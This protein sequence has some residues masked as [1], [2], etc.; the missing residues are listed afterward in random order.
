MVNTTEQLDTSSAT[1]NGLDRFTSV[2]ALLF[3][4]GF[5]SLVLRAFLECCPPI[6]AS[7]STLIDLQGMR[8]TGTI[9]DGMTEEYRDGMKKW[10]TKVGTEVDGLLID[11]TGFRGRRDYVLEILEHHYVN[12]PGFKDKID[13]IGKSNLVVAPFSL[14]S[15]VGD[16]TA[17]FLTDHGIG[18]T[19]A[20]VAIPPKSVIT[21]IPSR[22]PDVPLRNRE[23]VD[24][25]SNGKI[26]LWYVDAARAAGKDPKDN[27]LA[28][29]PGLTAAPVAEVIMYA[30]MDP[31]V[32]GSNPDVARSWDISQI[33]GT[34]LA[35]HPCVPSLASS[36]ASPKAALEELF[37]SSLASLDAPVGLAIFGP[38]QSKEWIRGMEQEM[39]Q[40]NI[41]LSNYYAIKSPRDKIL[42]L[43]LITP[44]E[45][46]KLTSHLQ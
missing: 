15:S 10:D 41:T 17:H 27:Y 29:A 14:A 38:I 43:F 7:G 42:G 24:R 12:T 26:G 46:L 45:A 32:Y 6:N 33:I 44:S 19:I 40:R 3:A 4:G 2:L 8:I 35:G 9:L 18:T 22:E 31:V 11:E 39:A 30:I 36:T 16:A 37:D 5:A 21:E 34:A 25:A 20:I 23:L 28:I 1:R 13:V